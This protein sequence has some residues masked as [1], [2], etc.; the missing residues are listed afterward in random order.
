MDEL[1]ERID[2]I[3]ATCL[4]DVEWG[5]LELPYRDESELSGCCFSSH[6]VLLEAGLPQVGH[7][8]AHEAV[9]GQSRPS[10]RARDSATLDGEH[11][12]IGSA[13][14]R[15]TRPFP[16]SDFCSAAR[17]AGRRW[18]PAAGIQ[19][20][21]L[22]ARR[23]GSAPNDALAQGFDL[24]RREGFQSPIVGLDIPLMAG[25]R[26]SLAPP[27]AKRSHES[28]RFPLGK[29]ER[30]RRVKVREL[31]PIIFL[32]LAQD[33]HGRFPESHAPMRPAAS[34]LTSEDLATCGE[35]EFGVSD[36]EFHSTTGRTVR[37]S[38]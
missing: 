33:H 27:V 36:L 34:R 32:V 6:V 5:E 13:D 31:D 3:L 24:F 21:G 35:V 8:T 9:N 26:R 7:L 4:S 10:G 16:L 2:A 25:A 14:T 28:R 12:V 37:M 18:D 22:R 23:R 38:F 19:V 20:A 17:K 11:A 29:V 15:Q 1:G 30:L